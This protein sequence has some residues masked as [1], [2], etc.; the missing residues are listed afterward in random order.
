MHPIIQSIPHYPEYCIQILQ[1]EYAYIKVFWLTKSIFVNF[2]NREMTYK[3]QANIPETIYLAIV[4][5]LPALNGYKMYS[6]ICL[7]LSKPD[8]YTL[9]IN[10]TSY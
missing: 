9:L 6:C 3:L 4:L 2:L 1:M 10:I 8:M 5:K 7:A